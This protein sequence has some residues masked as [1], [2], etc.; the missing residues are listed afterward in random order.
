MCFPCAVKSWLSLPACLPRC[1]CLLPLSFC[2]H[3]P[4]CLPSDWARVVLGCSDCFRSCPPTFPSLCGGTVGSLA[5]RACECA[6]PCNPIGH[7]HC[8]CYSLGPMYSEGLCFRSRRLIRRDTVQRES[9]VVREPC[10]ASFHEGYCLEFPAVGLK[11]AQSSPEPPQL[12]AESLPVLVQ[13][14]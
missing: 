14:M 7:V 6:L 13:A 3:H 2:W 11:Y 8:A 10:P 9:S 12:P 4:P 1:I 5:S